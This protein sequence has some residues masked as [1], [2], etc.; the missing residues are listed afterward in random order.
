MAVSAAKGG[1]ARDDE[2]HCSAA[3]FLRG[4]AVAMGAALTLT[5]TTTPGSVAWADDEMVTLGSGETAAVTTMAAAAAAADDAD[6]AATSSAVVLDVAGVESAATD[7]A[8]AAAATSAVDDAEMEVVEMSFDEVEVGQA[9]DI[10]AQKA[11]VAE[12]QEKG[13]T[14]LEQRAIDNNQRIKQ[15]NNA[16]AE[17]PTFVRE[18]Y[19]V[20]CITAPGFVTQDDGLVYKDFEVGVG[21][22]PTDGQEVIFHYIAY[23]ENGGTIDSTYRKSAPASTRLG[24]NGM[25]PGFEEGLKGM[26]EGGRRRVVVPPE[27]GPPTG[28]ATF[29]SAKQWEVFDIELIKIKSCE[30][31]QTSFMVS[32]VVCQ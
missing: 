27:L 25:I 14:E 7:S 31:V 17:F 20:R 21:A 24:I 29:F 18:G 12:R 28:P 6:A 22:S 1:A 5:L 2:R 9:P 26:K 10:A 8:A 15:Y 11:K 13:L 30:R 32:S 3:S 4:A 19:D 23:N 16:P